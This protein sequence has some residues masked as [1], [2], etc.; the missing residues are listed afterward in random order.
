[1]AAPTEQQIKDFY[2]QYVKQFD[3]VVNGVIVY[4]AMH[5]K[6]DELLAAHKS[7]E[8]SQLTT[9]LLKYAQTGI[10]P[11]AMDWA[12]FGDR[13]NAAK[14]NVPTI[15]LNRLFDKTY[16]PDLLDFQKALHAA[17]IQYNA[18]TSGT[19]Q[20]GFIP[21]IIIA[22]VLIVAAFTADDIVKQVDSSTAQQKR[23]ADA[24]NKLCTDQNLSSADCLALAKQQQATITTTEENKPTSFLGSI[25]NIALIGLAA[26]LGITILNKTSHKQ[27]A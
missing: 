4:W 13:L 15:R 16:L 6:F 25:E 19:E 23:L 18:P 10:L 24:T 5:K 26:F 27:A 21:L 9:N 14:I 1:M 8:A 12:R 11:A 17:K 20:T 22:V 3:Y 7:A 2:A